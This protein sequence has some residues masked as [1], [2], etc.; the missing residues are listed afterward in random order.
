[1]PA[2]VYYGD[3]A[4]GGWTDIENQSYA[5]SS[6]D[7]EATVT[8]V[9]GDGRFDQESVPSTVELSVGRVD[10]SR[11]PYYTND[12]E[13]LG[14]TGAAFETELL[15]RYLNKD[16][17]FRMGEFEFADRA[18]LAER[19]GDDFDTQ[20]AWRNY[21]SLVGAAN[22]ALGHQTYSWLH[23]MDDLETAALFAEARSTAADGGIGM[24]LSDG[25]PESGTTDAKVFRSARPSYHVFTRFSASF[26]TD[27]NKPDN[28][29]QSFLARDGYGLASVFVRHE[30]W[31]IRDMGIGE[32]RGEAHRA[33]QVVGTDDDGTYRETYYNL[34]GDPSLRMDIVKPASNLVATDAAGGTVDL[35]WTASPDPQV[36]GYHVYRATVGT[37]NYTRL[38][39]GGHVAGTTYQDAGPA[40]DTA[41]Y[42]YMVRAVKLEVSSGTYYNLSQGVFSEIGGGG[43]GGMMMSGFANFGSD[44]T[45]S[46]DIRS[47]RSTRFR[48]AAWSDQGSLARQLLASRLRSVSNVADSSDAA[49]SP[50]M[51][52]EIESARGL[53]DGPRV[54]GR[55]ALDL[56]FD[57][58]GR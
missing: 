37:N 18:L 28:F 41:T 43:G 26:I 53:T 16:H 34:L 30:N 9:P 42:Q 46:S 3:V 56:A 14:L 13:M 7:P 2:D 44:E 19:T 17:A 24:N 51:S 31:N 22:V 23:T 11:M 1:M 21:P 20:D 47:A 36:L 50:S 4:G 35:T 55:G 52:D 25:I 40:A 29:M 6:T 39:V 5:G 58:I 45:A 8:N 49:L 10:L 57:E 54:A 12:P 38:T 32:T 33:A 15:R 27:W 48:G